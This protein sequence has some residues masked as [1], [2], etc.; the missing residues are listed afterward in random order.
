LLDVAGLPVDSTPG[1][2]ADAVR[3][4]DKAA[5]HAVDRAA[6]AL[7]IALASVI[8]VLDIPAIV[9]G[10]HLGMIADEIHDQLD[11]QLRAR[12]LSANW[13]SPVIE[14]PNSDSAPAATGAAYKVLETVLDH[15]ARWIR[16]V[17]AD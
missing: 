10:G 17:V 5:R 9:L 1:Q 8:N 12:V 3:A 6:W 2:L 4:G 7:G 13:V 14:V 15:P 16:R 11:D